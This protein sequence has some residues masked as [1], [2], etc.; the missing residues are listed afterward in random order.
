MK[1]LDMSTVCFVCASTVCVVVGVNWDQDR[2]SQDH[3]GMKYFTHNTQYGGQ[4]HR[5]HT[6]GELVPCQR[7]L[8]QLQQGTRWFLCI[9]YS[10]SDTRMR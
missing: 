8:V 10:L 6:Q 9:P 5:N 7:L 2:N 1:I 3:T 4:M